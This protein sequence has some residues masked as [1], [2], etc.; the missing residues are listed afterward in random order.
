MV[1]GR[2]LKWMRAVRSVV[3]YIVLFSC[4]VSACGDPPNNEMQQAQGAIDAARAAGAEAYARDELTAAQQSLKNARQA[5]EARDFR[6][7]LNYALDSGERARN[8]A[9]QAADGKAAVADQAVRALAEAETA[10]SE[11]G[12]ALRT[13]ERRRVAVSTLTRARRTI[14]ATSA[15]VQKARATF[16]QGNYEGVASALAKPI[17]DIRATTRDL[18]KATA[19]A[20]RPR[21]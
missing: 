4:L 8:A 7:A 3:P 19:P 6:L 18:Q 2:I 13:A 20:A 17:A 5:V 11:A 21:R 12:A 14:S 1:N 15:A 16:G 10:L 9:K